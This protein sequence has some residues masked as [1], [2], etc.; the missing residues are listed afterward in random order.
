MPRADAAGHR[1]RCRQV[2]ARRRAGARLHAARAQGAAVQA[3]EHVEQ[4]RG[5]RRWRRDRPRPGVA[6]A[7]LRRRAGSRHEPGAAEAAIGRRGADRRLRPGA[8]ARVGA[9]LPRAGA[10]R[11]CRRCWRPS[12]GSPPTPISSW[13]K[14]P[15]ARP[16][17][18]CAPATSPIWAL[19][20]PPMCRSCWSATSSA[21]ASSPS[22]SART[23][24]CRR[25]SAARLVGYIVNK[26]RGDVRLFDGGIAAIGERTGLRV[27]RRRAV[28]RRRRRCCRPRIRWRCGLRLPTGGCCGRPPL[29]RAGRAAREAWPD[30][31]RRAAAAAHRQFRRSRPAARRARGR[32]RTWSGRASR[33]RAMP[34][35]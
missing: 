29:P 18:I 26:F 7:R 10:E 13:S 32:A 25:T 23:R 4:R 8:G 27:L 11:C 6:G 19:P 1:L 34:R 33:C 21:A 14:A 20:R 24:C 2:A 28:F 9:R 35:W 12:R 30:Q 5:H 17:S 31:D 22:W 15:A 3:A 16:R